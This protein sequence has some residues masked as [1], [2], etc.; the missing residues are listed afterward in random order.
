MYNT[1]MH[2]PEFLEAIKKK[3]TDQ[4]MRIHLDSLRYSISPPAGSTAQE[5]QQVRY[6]LLKLDYFT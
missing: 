5:K 1:D 4:G 3:A 6:S 2:Y